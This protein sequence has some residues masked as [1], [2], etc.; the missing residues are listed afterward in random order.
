M[1]AVIRD[2]EP[3]DILWWK[4]IPNAQNILVLFIY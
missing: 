3:V 4:N 2:T 1:M